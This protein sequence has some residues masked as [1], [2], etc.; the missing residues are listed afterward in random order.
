MAG[1]VLTSNMPR[2]QYTLT[3]EIVWW[4]VL[5]Q[6]HLARTR[7]I[8]MTQALDDAIQERF[9]LSPGDWDDPE[10]S[11]T[12]D[13]LRETTHTNSAPLATAVFIRTVCDWLTEKYDFVDIRD[14]GW[15]D[16]SN[17]DN[18]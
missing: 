10:R 1:M 14:T 3:V 2:P 15:P 18:S 11:R 4:A 17:T 6:L 16:L 13:F 9:G 5:K 7:H 8:R 12:A